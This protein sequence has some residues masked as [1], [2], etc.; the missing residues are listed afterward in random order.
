MKRTT[1]SNDALQS[2]NALS[3][4][5]AN[6]L[7]L[8]I[9]EEQKPPGTVLGTEALLANQF[10]VS[11][12]VIREAIGQLRGLGIVESRQGLG[13]CVANG[14]AIN[15]IAKVL[16]PMASDKVSWSKLCHMRFVLEVGSIPLAVERIT[17]DRID[18]MRTLA[19]EMYAL[20]KSKRPISREVE[21]KIARYEIEFHQIIFD[22]AGCEFTEQIHSLLG[23]YFFE[24]SGDRPHRSIPTIKDMEDHVK[25]V[26]AIAERNV[27]KAV[28]VMVDHIR[29]IL[30]D[31]SR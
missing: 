31:E 18:R 2:R 15:I 12:T 16:A 22:A 3:T 19:D 7:C 23:E 13:L 11:R 25:L 28:D 21:E 17:S 14:D 6:R 24:S 27:G 1:K 9:R 30:L 20:V 5:I 29:N 4:E 8:S 10:G 26:N